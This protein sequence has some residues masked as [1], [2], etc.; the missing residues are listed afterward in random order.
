MEIIR[1]GFVEKNELACRRTSLDPY[2]TSQAVASLIDEPFSPTS[3]RLHSQSCIYPS[4]DKEQGG[5]GRQR[6][7]RAGDVCS[8]SVHYATR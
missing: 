5:R 7:G 8:V 2:V 3:R 1:R 4:I 6:L